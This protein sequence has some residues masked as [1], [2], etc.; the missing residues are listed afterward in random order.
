MTA[1]EAA[2]GAVLV[3]LVPAASYLGL[4]GRH[5]R[6]RLREV[7]DNQAKRTTFALHS[8]GVTEVLVEQASRTWPD[9]SALD[10]VRATRRHVIDAQRMLMGLSPD[11]DEKQQQE[12]SHDEWTQEF[13]VG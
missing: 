9:V 8:L 13:D 7:L 4:S 12:C 10:K 5:Y 6:R 2:L 11:V 1:L 3:T